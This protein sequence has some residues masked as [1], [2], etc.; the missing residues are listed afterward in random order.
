[1]AD[2]EQYRE[3]Y[4]RAFGEEPEVRTDRYR[5]I[6]AEA[7]ATREWL[8]GPLSLILTQGTGDVIFQDTERY[9]GVENAEDFLR[10]CTWQVDQYRA[11]ISEHEPQDDMEQA[12]QGILDQ[13]ADYMEEV[14]LQAH[15]IVQKEEEAA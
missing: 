14:C 4:E 13:I 2:W 6:A 11:K 7:E 5:A 9:R 15:L 8:G 3:S 10:M 1:M 12:D